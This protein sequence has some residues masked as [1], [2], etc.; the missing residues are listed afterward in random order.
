MDLL[1]L[2]LFVISA[3]A[4]L[5][6]PGPGIAS[7]IA[8]GRASGFLLGLRYYSGLQ[9]GLAIAAGA[10]AAGLLSVLA[11]MPGAM[12]AMELAAAAYLAYLAYKIATAPLS[13]GASAKAAPASFGSGLFLGLS[14]PKALLAF[15]SLFAARPIVP[16]NHQADIILKWCL[17]VVVMIIVDLG[18]LAFGAWIGRATMRPSAE[19]AS[20]VALGMLV[21]V[22][23][24]WALL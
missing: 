24:L 4:L 10:S 11:L 12:R 13:E 14:N 17:V 15:A 16:T 8:V 6:S 5:G 21:L 3:T 1:T 23:A 20:N 9:V 7:L 22:A 18:W 2:G 19:R